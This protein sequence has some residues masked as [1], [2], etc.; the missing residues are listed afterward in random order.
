MVGTVS[1]ALRNTRSATCHHL[2]YPCDKRVEDITFKGDA[3]G[4]PKNFVMAEAK[5]LFS[6]HQTLFSLGSAGS[7]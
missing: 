5:Y 3:T 2:F 6:F 7:Q 4:R 1:L